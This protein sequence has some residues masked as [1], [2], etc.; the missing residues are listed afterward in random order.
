MADE[1]VTVDACVVCRK[2]VRKRQEGLHCDR[3][4]RWQ[5]R[6][7]NSGISLSFHRKVVKGIEELQEWVCVEY[8]KEKISV[9]AH[10]KVGLGP[11]F[12]GRVRA[13]IPSPPL[14]NPGYASDS[15]SLRIHDSLSLRRSSTLSNSCQRVSRFFIIVLFFIFSCIFIPLSRESDQAL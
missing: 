4:Q 5:H 3:C 14:Q 11:A 15:Y 1:D 13:V 2:L 7:C 10:L 12:S 6:T 9:S 8:Q